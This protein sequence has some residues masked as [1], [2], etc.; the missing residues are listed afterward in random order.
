MNLLDFLNDSQQFNETQ[1]VICQYILNH[2]E[3]VVKMSARSLAKVTY[4]NPSTII[5]F[6]KK[7]GY[8]NY[9]D[10]KIHL[11]HDLKEYKATDI[12]I[13]E[14]EK[15]ISVIDKISELEKNVIEKTKNQL[16]V[17]QL[18]TIA[19]ILKETTYIDF[20]SMDANECIADYACH[21]FFL[22]KKI[23]NNYTT[24]NQQLYLTMTNLKDHVIFV[25]TRTGEDKKILKVVQELRKKKNVHIIAITG[26]SNSPVAKNCDEVLPAIHI[27]SFTEL[28]DMIFQISAQYIINCLFS[29]LLTDDYQS[30]V[31]FNDEYGKIYMK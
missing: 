21:L 20:I 16:S 25:I 22:A 29:L 7:I 10:F 27:E 13:K 12:E 15:S 14:K 30:I 1:N 28:R 26:R 23:S 31:Q 9:N 5:R 24:S 17:Q 19:N 4:T 8:E 18:E 11:V 6:V 2:S 3:E